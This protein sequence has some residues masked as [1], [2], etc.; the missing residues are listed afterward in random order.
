MV[1][2]LRTADGTTAPVAELDPHAPAPIASVL[3]GRYVVRDHLHRS[4]HAD[5]YDARDI[6]DFPG[7]FPGVTRILAQHGLDP[8]RDLIPVA[9]AIMSPAP[10]PRIVSYSRRGIAGRNKN[11][12]TPTAVARPV[13]AAISRTIPT[14]RAV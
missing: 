1:S 11:G 4:K 13:A 5:V 3:A 12:S 8:G 14:A 9:A 6:D 7:R 2:A 10:M